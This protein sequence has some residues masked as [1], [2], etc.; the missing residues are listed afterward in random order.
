MD[1]LNNRT[2][3][4]L[5]SSYNMYYVNYTRVKTVEKFSPPLV[6]N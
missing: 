5:I 3:Q 2:R 1:G 6:G 4:L